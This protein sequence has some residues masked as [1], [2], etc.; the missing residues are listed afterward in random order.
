V[1]IREAVERSIERLQG[2]MPTFVKVSGCAS[3]HNQSLPQV[4]VGMARDLGWKYDSAVTTQQYKAVMGMLKGMRLPA[5][6]NSDVVPDAPGSMPYLLLGLAAQNHAPDAVTDAAVLNL[7]AKQLADGS[8]TVWAPRPPLE[9]SSITATALTIRVLD[10]YAP[11]GRRADIRKR[12]ERARNWLRTA[13]PRT[14]EELAMRMLG[15]AWGKADRDEVAAAARALIAA[16]A[17]DGGWRQLPG[18]A[19]DAYATGQ[20]LVALRWAGIKQASDPAYQRGVAYL[21]RTQETDGTWHVVSRAFPFQP[22]KES[23]F[24]HGKDQWISSAGTSWAAM[25]L[26]LNVEPVQRMTLASSR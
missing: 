24:P 2:A 25:A 12:I 6:E 3:C 17:E 11:Q 16:Q 18:L 10:M 1:A 7:A 15:L 4:A 20:A 13:K 5:I 22:Y 9:F 8:F 21:M 19:T 26:M 14:N 23:G